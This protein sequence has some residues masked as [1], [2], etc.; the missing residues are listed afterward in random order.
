ML[1]PRIQNL[2]R[3]LDVMLPDRLR[4]DLERHQDLQYVFEFKGEAP[5][6]EGTLTIYEG[7]PAGK[8]V[9]VE[10]DWFHHSR[11]WFRRTPVQRLGMDR[12]EAYIEYV[13]DYRD[14]VIVNLDQPLAVL[15]VAQEDGA[16]VAY[17]Q[18][19]T[20]GYNFDLRRTLPLFPL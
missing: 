20:A 19:L 16:A 5:I 6:I 7:R 12:Y 13:S 11:V 8:K 18:K 9:A 2:F 4:D 1:H 3:V 15:N 14:D 17:V 10:A